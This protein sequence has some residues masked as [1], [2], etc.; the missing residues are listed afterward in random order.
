M[1]SKQWSNICNR[2]DT[3]A[4]AGTAAFVAGIPR[5][6]VLVNGPLW[7]YFY[8]MRYLEHAQYD[9][10]ERFHDCQP[11][12]NAIVYGTE[13]FLSAALE[14][15]TSDGHKPEL[16]FVESSCSLSLIG[17]D[18]AG[19]VR[20]HNLDFPWLVMD[21]GG[22]VGGFAEGYAKASVTLFEKFAEE[23]KSVNPLAVNLLGLSDFYYNG[24]ADRE[25][26]CRM[27]TAAGYV[28]NA[29]PGGSSTLDELKNI[30]SAA[31][32]IVCNEEL[33]LKSA[34][35]LHKRFGTPYIVAG[36]PYGVEGSKEWMLAVNEKL[37][38][39][40]LDGF[41]KECTEQKNYQTSLCNDA[42]SAWGSM[43]FDKVI[44]SA[45]GTSALCMAHALRSEWCD[46]GELTVI[47]QNAVQKIKC[48]VADN[49]YFAGT[50]NNDIEKCLQEA[51]NV[52]LLASS[53]EN[54]YLQR[55]VGC[56]FRSC[57]IA[58]PSTDEMNFI[59]YP[60]VGLRGS[61]HMLQRL[62]NIFISGMV[63]KQVQL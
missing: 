39:V 32:N 40:N 4:L 3:C 20:K 44:V 45:P 7:C 23:Q 22:L 1:C 29:V 15:L 2:V 43:W 62:W 28:V 35:Y 52:L 61:A 27:L 63:T 33:G 31:L 16:L 53:S 5:S 17:D 19:I 38:A 11:D 30:S 56:K 46:M 24:K 13:K 6:E 25:E 50:D 8:A 48:E 9:M 55:K 37:E 18:V 59:N 51:N 14:R 36:M 10:G 21:C 26:I 47:C 49:I 60:Y 41:L 58:Y 54:S 57:N 34:E 12:N 42:R